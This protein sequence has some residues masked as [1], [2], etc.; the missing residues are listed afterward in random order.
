VNSRSLVLDPRANGPR[1]SAN[2]GFACGRFAETV[3]GTAVVTLL[4]PP[5]MGVALSV[6]PDGDGV[7]VRLGETPIAA[8]HVE[9]PFEEQPPVL[10]TLDEAERAREAH[11]W[12]GMVHDLS[13]CIVCSPTRP[14]G[15]R[16]TPGPLPTRPEV[17]ATPYRPHAQEAVDGIV[18][19]EAVWGA[20]DCPSYP[21]ELMTTGRLALLGRLSVFRRR[22][23]SVGE[24]LMVIGWTRD[25]GR[26][27]YTTASAIVDA[28]GTVAACGRAVWVELR[29]QV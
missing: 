8:V 23:I 3:G 28:S 19:A 11:P 4:A 27:S 25:R 21:A 26:R 10:P 15:M 16:V 13:N 1:D 9:P 20:L 22:E 2:G 17:L 29:A 24:D 12:R 6:S 14:D 5:P 7:S 18:R